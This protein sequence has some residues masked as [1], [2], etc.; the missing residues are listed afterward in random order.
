[1]SYKRLHA[2]TGFIILVFVIL[3]LGNHL[4]A[5]KGVDQHL[6]VMRIIRPFYRNIFSESILL[7]AI[8]FQ[9]YSGIS[10]FKRLNAKG[11]KNLLI[12]KWT[13]LYL[14]VFF[15]FHLSAVFMGRLILHLDTNFYFGAAGLNS[16]PLSLFFI[17]YYGLAILSIVLHAGNGIGSLLSGQSKN[18]SLSGRNILLLLLGA[19]MAILIIYGLTGRFS[20]IEIPENYKVLTGKK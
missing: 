4:A 7:L 11:N 2:F 17:S 16:W 13:G 8:A 14:A 5:L 1:M 9:I 15:L 19:S 18:K 20:G 10:M 12:Q 3:H 6:E